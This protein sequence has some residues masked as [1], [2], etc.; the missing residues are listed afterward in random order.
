MTTIKKD[1]AHKRAIEGARVKNNIYGEVTDYIVRGALDMGCDAAFH[2]PSE[3]VVSLYA[4]TEDKL[5][6]V[7]VLH[8][9]SADERPAID[10]D[11]VLSLIASAEAAGGVPVYAINRSYC[12]KIKFYNLDGQ[13][14]TWFD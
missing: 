8:Q 10:A 6:L 7:H 11:S 9:M 14:I 2:N 3:S 12:R 1:S 13:V 4:R 5:Y